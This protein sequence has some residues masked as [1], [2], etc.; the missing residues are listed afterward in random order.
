MAE[1]IF[2]NQKSEIPIPHSIT[3]FILVGGKNRRMK[4][5][6]PLL[7]FK[8]QRIIDRSIDILKS[9]F[10]DVVIV[11]SQENA[12]FYEFLE[13]EIITDVL[14]NLGPI[15][16]LLTGL[17]Y[18][19]TSEGFFVAGDM[20]FIDSEVIRS[21]VEKYYTNEHICLIP[22]IG[23]IP[24]YLHGIYTKSILPDV[25]ESIKNNDL[26]IKNLIRKISV[27]NENIL[28]EVPDEQLKSFTNINT[29]E[30]FEK[31]R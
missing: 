21:Q 11:A 6:K 25:K 27:N 7:S 9:L 26:S 5:E 10:H 4:D 20:P 12:K 13:I 24:Q 15:G 2:I 28:F 16:G 14:S 17:E 19:K 1:E 22:R 31:L 29:P 3:A 23:E 8:G 18:M 30:D